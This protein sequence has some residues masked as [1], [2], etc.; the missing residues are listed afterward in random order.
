MLY[1][2]L[3]KPGEIVTGKNYSLQLKHLAEK[4]QEKPV[5]LQHNNVKPNRSSVI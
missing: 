1:Y 3:L 5:I 2:E 4:M